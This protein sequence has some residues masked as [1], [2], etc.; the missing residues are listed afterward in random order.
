MTSLDNKGFSIT[1]L[2]ANDEIVQ[3]LDVPAYT[4]GWTITGA[5][6]AGLKK[7]QATQEVMPSSHAHVEYASTSPLQG[8]T[9]CSI[10]IW[11][12]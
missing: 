8:E 7:A 4:P 3:Y 10:D 6:Q 12:P 2:N 9:S 1:L 5:P 11:T